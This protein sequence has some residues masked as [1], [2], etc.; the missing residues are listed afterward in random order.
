MGNLLGKLK[1][2]FSNR[3]MEIVM[4]GLENSGKTTLTSQLSFEKPI[5][6]GPTIGLDVRTFKKDKVTMKCWDLGGQGKIKSAV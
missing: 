4:V 6:K 3:Q 2:L 5:E 1:D